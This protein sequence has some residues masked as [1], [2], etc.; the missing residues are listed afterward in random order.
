MR[1]LTFTATFTSRKL[2]HAIMYMLTFVQ[3]MEELRGLLQVADEKRQA[4]LTELSVKH[5]KVKSCKH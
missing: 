5:Q 4:S 1:S 3:M 2:E